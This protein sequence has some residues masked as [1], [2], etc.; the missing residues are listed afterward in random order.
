M[1]AMTTA[2]INPLQYSTFA[3]FVLYFARFL[4]SFLFSV[5]PLMPA[6]SVCAYWLIALPCFNILGRVRMCVCLYGYVCTQ[7]LA[8]G[9]SLY[10]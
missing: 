1:T 6:C 7:V 5:L 8:I 4:H 10:M 3:F 9:G 2:T